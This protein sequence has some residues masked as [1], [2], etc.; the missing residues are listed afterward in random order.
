MNVERLSRL[1]PACSD[2][3]LPPI[4]SEHFSVEQP[5]PDDK[6]GAPRH[7]IDGE[8]EP[9]SVGPVRPDGPGLRLLL[10]H[11]GDESVDPPKRRSA[12][13][14]PSAVSEASAARR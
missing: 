9:V 3:W 11:R 7:A 2:R 1:L 12:A 5:V 6:A 13:S 14:S 8:P 10:L 4:V